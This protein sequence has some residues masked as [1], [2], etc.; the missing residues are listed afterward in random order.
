MVYKSCY[1]KGE[2]KDATECLE[3]F[4]DNLDLVQRDLDGV[5]DK[6]VQS[7][8]WSGAMLVY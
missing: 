5:I 3:E 2:E 4:R 8:N 7:Y 6:Y 1:D